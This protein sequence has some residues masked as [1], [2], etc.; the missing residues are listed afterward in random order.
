VY[1]VIAEANGGY[2]KGPPTNGW[3]SLPLVLALIAA[4]AVGWVTLD[5]HSQVE[6]EENGIV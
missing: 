4:V 6:D 5:R 1:V 2:A 3:D